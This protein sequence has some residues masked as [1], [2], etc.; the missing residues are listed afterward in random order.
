[1]IGG[2]INNFGS[3]GAVAG[4]RPLGVNILHDALFANAT[5]TFSFDSVDFNGGAGRT[6]G[7]GIALYTVD[8]AAISLTVNNGSTF[9]NVYG[10]AIITQNESTTN[11][12]VT[13]TVI[14]NAF[15]APL[16]GG[17][18]SVEVAS[19][20][21]GMTGNVA[22]NIENNTFNN[23]GDN[24]AGIAIRV[25]LN[26]AANARTQ[27]NTIHNNTIN[28]ADTVRGIE[29]Y[30]DETSGLRLRMNNN[31]TTGLPDAGALVITGAATWTSGEA[32]IAAINNTFGTTTTIAG[33]TINMSGAA[34]TGMQVFLDNFD[35]NAPNATLGALEVYNGAAGRL[36]LVMTNND[37]TSNVSG[38]ESLFV[39]ASGGTLC[40]DLNDDVGGANTTND[41]FTLSQSAGTFLIEN[42]TTV[43]AVQGD[44]PGI[45]AGAIFGTLTLQ[46]GECINA[47][48]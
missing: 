48:P 43:G 44:N 27:T 34:G 3:P 42:G 1:M 33:V 41:G 20:G 19:G 38:S 2:A 32:D 15:N 39:G 4:Q 17:Q 35:V 14:G 47:L 30:L 36:D 12:S 22:F 26:Q 31:T 9:V 10:K 7:G 40:L 6:L 28:D 24:L 45:G 23:F 16:A 46:A 18:S 8:N 11:G 5:G 13:T 29:I 21:A 25:N 37:L